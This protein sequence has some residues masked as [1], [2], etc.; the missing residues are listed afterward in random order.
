MKLLE[1][2]FELENK[3]L[4]KERAVF[5]RQWLRHPLRMGAIAPSSRALSQLMC[6]AVNPHPEEYMIELGAGTGSL[7]EQLLARGV[8]PQRLI[9]IEM[10]PFLCS[11]LEKKFPDV[12]VIC[13]DACHLDDLIPAPF[14]GHVSA[15]VSGLPLK[16]IPQKKVD[17]IVTS[18]FRVLSPHG[19][20]LQF[21]YSLMAPFSAQTLGLAQ[22]RVGQIFFNLPPASVWRFFVPREG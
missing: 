15:V 20:F 4:I 14:K 9:V 7:T 8:D 2:I 18:S 19:Q 22:E 5:L 17:Q 21:T 10:D 3:Q 1:K 11:Y 13:G 12:Q 16:V 6:Q